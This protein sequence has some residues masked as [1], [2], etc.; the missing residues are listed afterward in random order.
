M[1]PRLVMTLLIAPLLLAI[2]CG[3]SDG[4][5]AGTA[6]SS[7]GD[8][9]LRLFEVR[10]FGAS[11]FVYD[12][13]LPPDLARLLNPGLTDDTPEDD[14]VAIPVPADGVL[15]GSYHI[16]RRDGTNE[17]W[18]SYDVPGV[19]TDVE[20]SLRDLLDETPWQVTGGQSN[21][22]F[23]AVSFQSTVSGDLEGFATVQALPSTP[24]YPVTVERD[25]QTVEVELPRGAFIPEIDARFRELSTGLEVTDVLSDELL[26]E[27]DVIVAVGELAVASERDLFTAFRAL[28]N[29]GDPR[30]A[31]LYR[32][33]IV[34]PSPASDPVFITPRT[35]PLP[36]DFPAEFLISDDLSVVDVTW[37][38][39]PAGDIYQVTM[40]SPRSAFELV[41]DYR[42]ALESAGW[43]LVGDEAQGFGTTLSFEDVPNGLAG[44]ATIDEFESDDELVSVILQLQATRGNN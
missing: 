8:R 35:R 33:T 7:V 31:V 5:P 22:L 20:A 44:I 2:A 28:S 13:Q 40:V 6:G 30:T 11:L 3:D 15:I 1:R 37:N 19:D 36:E 18:L 26:Q 27:D 32:L 29:L 16:R 38:S 21:E 17:I 23:G 14:I 4:S 43:E 24:T 34:S 12:E 42:S 9:Y 39:E 41:D 25:G 10:D